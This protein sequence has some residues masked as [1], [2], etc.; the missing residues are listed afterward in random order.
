M[1]SAA[2]L[3][4]TLTAAFK[5]CAEDK[6]T[7]SGLYVGESKLIQFWRYKSLAV[8]KRH[9]PLYPPARTHL[10]TSPS[11]NPFDWQV[12]S[13]LPTRMYGFSQLNQILSPTLKNSWPEGRTSKSSSS[14]K[15][16]WHWRIG[17]EKINKIN[18]YIIVCLQPNLFEYVANLFRLIQD[19]AKS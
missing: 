11:N 4:L 7:V 16:R 13:L 17:A 10:G 18:L 5:S 1:V 12:I 19:Q 14:I 3:A 15:G 2:S 9:K 8:T 6:E